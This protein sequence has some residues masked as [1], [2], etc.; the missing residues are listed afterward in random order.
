MCVIHA[1]ELLNFGVLLNY[2]WFC[3]IIYCV[4]EHVCLFCVSLY[5]V[6]CASFKSVV[7]Q[8]LSS[9]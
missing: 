1:F 6:W 8:L 9:S 5:L 2:L 3:V 7:K 4:S